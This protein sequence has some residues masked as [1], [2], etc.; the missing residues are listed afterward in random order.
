L[1][2]RTNVHA[3]RRAAPAARLAQEFRVQALV[4]QVRDLARDLVR[5]RGAVRDYLTALP[6]DEHQAL[7]RLR[8]ELA[9]ERRPDEVAA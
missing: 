8:H 3:G 1:N 5:L 6:S 2:T 4:L 9:R 7:A